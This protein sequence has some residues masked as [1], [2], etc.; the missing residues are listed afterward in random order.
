[1]QWRCISN[2][3]QR[4]LCDGNCHFSSQSECCCCCGGRKNNFLAV[5][6]ANFDQSFCW[7]AP[8]KPAGNRANCRTLFS[9]ACFAIYYE[10]FWA[11]KR[12][13]VILFV[14]AAILSSLA[15]KTAAGAAAE[16]STI[17]SFSRYCRWFLRKCFSAERAHGM[18]S[19][20]GILCCT[21][22]LDFVATENIAKAVYI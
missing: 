21:P 14:R 13:R 10:F 12:N 8:S 16:S 18:I 20:L 2:T 6:E 11:Q 7:F 22:L 1:L 4:A 5:F 9:A 19:T 17:L 3:M 15:T